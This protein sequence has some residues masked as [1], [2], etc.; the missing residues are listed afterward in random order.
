MPLRKLH[1]SPG[2]QAQP[3]TLATASPAHTSRNINVGRILWCLGLVLL[4]GLFGL[5]FAGLETK[6]GCVDNRLPCGLGE[7]CSSSIHKL[8]P[9]ECN[10]PS[11]F[12]AFSFIFISA[13]GVCLLLALVALVR[14]YQGKA[15]WFGK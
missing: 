2:D 10:N 3:T 5:M 8:P 1:N 12:A 9:I 6:S 7:P 11:L 15:G 13:A 4:F 14:R